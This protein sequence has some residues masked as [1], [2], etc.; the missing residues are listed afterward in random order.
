MIFVYSKYNVLLDS[1]KIGIINLNYN[2][3]CL[4]LIFDTFIII[5][6]R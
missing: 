3:K 4:Q 5:I 1:L 2:P 6:F